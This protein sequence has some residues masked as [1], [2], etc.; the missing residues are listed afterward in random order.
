MY[1]NRKQI[2]EEFLKNL[3]RISNKE[4]QRR[5]WIEGRGPECHG[6]DEAVC[7]FFGDGDPIMEN[8]KDFGITESQYYL[9]KKFQDAFRD[10]SDENDFPQ[11]FIDTPEWEKIM[12]MAK[13]VLKAF[14]F[15][16]E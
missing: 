16:K 2:L 11:L 13:E 9:L 6:F 15:H 3:H 14:K 8:Y 7:D 10:F 4:Y 1:I 12:E 5:I